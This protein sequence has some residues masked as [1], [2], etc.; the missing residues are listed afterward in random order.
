MFHQLFHK[1]VIMLKI[2][3]KALK[4]PVIDHSKN[5]I[6]AV[7]TAHPW[8]T[9]NASSKIHFVSPAS[10]GLFKFLLPRG[11]SIWVK[12]VHVRRGEIIGYPVSPW[13]ST[14]ICVDDESCIGGKICWYFVASIYTSEHFSCVLVSLQQTGKLACSHA[15]SLQ[16]Y[17]WLYQFEWGCHTQH[18]LWR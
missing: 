15:S 17:F 7:V 16:Q 1:G 13:F 11:L 6:E 14:R 18:T 12:K 2:L 10:H 9:L 3:A 4:S 8:V 5:E